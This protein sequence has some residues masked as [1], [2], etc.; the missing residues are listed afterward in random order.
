MLL[1]E[2]ADRRCGKY[3][4]YLE[5]LGESTPRYDPFAGDV[6]ARRGDQ[7]DSPPAIYE[8]A[9]TLGQASAAPISQEPPGGNGQGHIRDLL[10][11][12]LHHTRDT[13]GGGGGWNLA[14]HGADAHAQVHLFFPRPAHWRVNELATSLKHL[15][16]SRPQDSLADQ[17]GKELAHLQPLLGLAGTAANAAGALG[18]G[19][20]ASATG[21]VLDAVAKTKINSVP[22]SEKNP[23]YVEKTSAR[24]VTSEKTD[25]VDGLVWTLPTELLQ[26]IGTRVTGTVS[27]SFAELDR[28]A[29]SQQPPVLRACAVLCLADGTVIRLPEEDDTYVKLSL[30]PTGPAEGSG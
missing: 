2:S 12:M 19:P 5:L 22:V 14:N 4:Y 15:P 13:H 21:H 23:W 9:W 1:C 20:M 11:K 17:A 25:I 3:L 18:A 30:K 16:P 29:L 10:N 7:K 26:T 28:P 24:V 6:L 27:V 8:Y